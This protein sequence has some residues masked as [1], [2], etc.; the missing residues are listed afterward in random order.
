[1]EKQYNVWIYCRVTSEKNNELLH[2][3]ADLLHEY[4]INNNC[5]C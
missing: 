4:A 2:Y 5:I 1:M 3:K